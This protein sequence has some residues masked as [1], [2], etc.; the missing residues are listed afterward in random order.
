M[1]DSLQHGAAAG[2]ESGGDAYETVVE[3]LRLEAAS[4]STLQAFAGRPK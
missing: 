1:N 3:L 2:T 4:G